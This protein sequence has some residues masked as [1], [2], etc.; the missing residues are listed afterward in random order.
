MFQKIGRDF[1]ITFGGS[2]SLL[3]NVNLP[4][5]EIII[6]MEFCRQ[7]IRTPH[8]EM[9]NQVHLNTVKH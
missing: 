2:K 3:K 4:D 6:M 1:L 9:G 8:K 7:F 5:K